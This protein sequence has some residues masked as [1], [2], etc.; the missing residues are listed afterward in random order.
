MQKKIEAK[1]RQKFSA[2]VIVV[3]NDSH[4]HNVP[5]DS[6]THFKITLVSSAFAGQSKVKRHQAIYQVLAVELAASIHA[7]AMR[8]Y[9]PEE[10][11]ARRGQPIPDSPDCLGGSKNDPG[12]TF[13]KRADL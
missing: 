2:Q 8:L 6:E 5:A 9:T 3:E 4:K 11:A 13:N 12:A 10:W 7:L 1:L